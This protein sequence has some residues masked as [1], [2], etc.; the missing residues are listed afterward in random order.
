MCAFR[1][2]YDTYRAAVEEYLG[3]LFP[4]DKPYGRLQEAMR[5]SLMAGGKRVR[6]VV[7]LAFCDL[8]GGEWRRAIPFAC[9]LELVHTYSLIHD[10]LP[11]MDDDD[12]RRGKPT[13][14]KVYGEAMA[15]LAGD[16]LQAEAFRLLATAPGVS[17]R[18]RAEAVAVLSKACGADGMVAG[19]VL[20]ILGL[21]R[22]R[23]EL[24]LLHSLKTG[25]M[26]QGAAELGCVAAGADS[27]RRE[28]AAEYARH[29]GLAFQ[30]RDD[31]LDVIA[32]Q[33]ELGKTVGSDRR[34]GKTTFV[35]LLGLEDCEALVA[36]ETAKAKAAIS[37]LPG[38]E[39]LLNLAE[40]LADRRS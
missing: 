23:G 26:I 38:C 29:I 14:H 31:I 17:D 3:G 9:A 13:C 6:P 10:D 40:R 21:T 8:M 7:T 39:F 37:D 25:A 11:A 1:L 34:D 28:Q 30:V 36:Q 15:I 27:R 20:D 33:Q 18:Q 4:P 32:D 5:Y 19:Q 35:D 22:S 2:R 12:L 16:A 24:E